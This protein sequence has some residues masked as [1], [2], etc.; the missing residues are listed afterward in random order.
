MYI[1]HFYNF[2]YSR[3][4]ATLAEAFEGAKRA[5]F[6]SVITKDGQRLGK[7]SPITGLTTFA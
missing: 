7:F 2:G 3:E 4:F 5:G 1:V 6:E